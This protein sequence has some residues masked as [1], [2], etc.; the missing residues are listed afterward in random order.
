MD[1][2]YQLLFDRAELPGPAAWFAAPRCV[3]VFVK[4]LRSTGRGLGTSPNPLPRLLA[5]KSSPTHPR[6]RAF[7]DTSGGCTLPPTN[8]APVGEELFKIKLP[9]EGTGLCQGAMLVGEP[10]PCGQF[11]A[12]R[13]MEEVSAGS[14]HA[15]SPPISP[16]VKSWSQKKRFKT[17]GGDRSV[18]RP[19]EIPGA[20]SVTHFPRE[21]HPLH[22]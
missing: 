13:V 18:R 14:S 5:P 1:V 6:L 8:M 7:S 9:L 4:R 20:L 17:P 16:T 3:S 2:C 12:G 22:V 21:G 19:L 10:V 15:K 11:P